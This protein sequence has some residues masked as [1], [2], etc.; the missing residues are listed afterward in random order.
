MPKQTALLRA[1]TLTISG[2][3][4]DGEFKRKPPAYATQRE[5]ESGHASN[6]IT[7][8]PPSASLQ[9]IVTFDRQSAG[10]AMVTLFTPE[11]T[12]IPVLIQYG[13]R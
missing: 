7:A 10:A 4:R 5:R 1:P 8:C 13:H 9:V 6:V 12:T 3:H 11:R 2:T